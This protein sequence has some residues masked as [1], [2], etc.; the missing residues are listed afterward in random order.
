MLIIIQNTISIELKTLSKA[1]LCKHNQK[2]KFQYKN[3][4]N[5]IK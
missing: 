1:D 2:Y 3:Q 4:Q 5:Q